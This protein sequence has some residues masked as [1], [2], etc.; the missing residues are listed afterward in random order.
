MKTEA[1]LSVVA[2]DGETSRDPRADD[3]RLPSWLTAAVVGTEVV[4]VVI[5]VDTAL[6]AKLEARS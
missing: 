5:V 6:G 1:V 3:T 2:S 4:E